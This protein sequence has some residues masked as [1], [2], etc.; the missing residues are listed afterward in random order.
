MIDLIIPFYNEEDNLNK[1]MGSICAQTKEHAA[2]VTFVNDH[3]TDRSV[4]IL[5]KWKE[6]VNFPMQIITPPQR[7]KYPGLVRQ[8]GIDHTRC[9][10]IMFCDGDDELLP[11]AFEYLSLSIRT[12]NA[13]VVISH[14]IVEG[15]KNQEY[16]QG[17]Q[18]GGMTWLH[19][20]IYRRK[21]LEDN[22]IRFQRG[23]NEDGTFNLWCLLSTDNIYECDKRTYLWKNNK[24]S[25]TRTQ[26]HFA[27]DSFEDVA[28][29][30]KDIYMRF[31]E[32]HSELFTKE[33]LDEEEEK[34][35]K[36][37]WVN[38]IGHLGLFY[39]WINEF[40]IY[41]TSKERMNE[42]VEI[43]EDFIGSTR[44]RPLLNSPELP[45]F[46]KSILAKDL[47]GI[48]YLTINDFLRLFDINCDLRPKKVIERF[49]GDLS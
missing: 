41:N 32:K 28:W 5:E 15:D 48:C 45:D 6:F 30:Y 12:S 26:E 35:I 24:K 34:L 3:S 18:N 33:E 23:Y 20:N 22:G 49:G 16:E 39:R 21:F 42:I 8:Y 14:F 13:D 36:K 40:F 9:E 7:L 27:R 29:G 17:I 2:M 44:L 43:I 11:H 37:Y 1:L 4:E 10:Y 47:K 46:Y 38:C 31:L 25:I 19:G